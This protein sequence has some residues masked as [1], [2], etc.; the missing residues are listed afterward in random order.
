ME[1]RRIWKLAKQ[2]K[3]GSRRDDEVAKV[4]SKA[5]GLRRSASEKLATAAREKRARLYIMRRC[6]SMLVRWRD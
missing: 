2:H 1:E 4:S 3:S 6:V 5:G